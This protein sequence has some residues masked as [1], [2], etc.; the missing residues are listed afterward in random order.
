MR[1]DVS[2]SKGDRLLKLGLFVAALLLIVSALAAP[3]GA[4]TRVITKKVGPITVAPYQVALGGPQFPDGPLPVAPNIEGF[5]TKMSVDVVDVKTGKPV[6]IRRIMLHHIVFMNFGTPEARRYD[7]F[8]GDGEERAKMELP[9][10][11]GY[12]IHPGE[13]WY[14]VW[15][16]MNHQ[17]VTDQVKIRYTMTVVTDKTLKPVI[18]FNFD[19]S[20]RRAGLVFDVP[21]GGKPGSVDVRKMSRPA[22]VAGRLV[23]GLGHVHGGAKSL[24]LTQPSCGNRTLYRSSPTW[25]LKKHPFYQVRPVLHEPGPINMSQ[26]TSARGIPV[27][28]GETLTLTS[29]YDNQYPHT[30]AMGLMV[31]YLAPDP[32]VTATN[33]APLPRDYKVLK[34][35]QKGRKKVPPRQIHIYDWSKKG[36]AI[37]VP[38]PRGAMQVATGDTT[39]V[40]DDFQFKAGN[41]S[42]PRGGTITWSFPGDVLHNVTLANGPEGFSSD[43]LLNGGTFSKTFTKPGTYTFFCELHPVGMIERVVVRPGIPAG[44]GLAPY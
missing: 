3:A 28:A 35:K 25:G 15:M 16:L 18:P 43:R 4:E 12:P 14:W 11:Y 32:K 13:Q 20:N 26:F 9:K 21:G 1:T 36:K 31:A 40:A 24:A 41:V 33:C 42:L 34:T 38:G 6:P 30:R 23:A 44:L 22:P 37:E 5:I 7:P 2:V 10:G 17:S 27:A 19:T 8:Y 39:V 29:R